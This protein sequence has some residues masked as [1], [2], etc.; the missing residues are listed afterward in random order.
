MKRQALSRYQRDPEGRLLLDVAADRTEDLYNNFDRIHSVREL[1]REPFALRF[2]ID[3]APNEDQRSRIARSTK[4][5]FLYLTDVQ[6]H[7]VRQ[8]VRRSLVLLVAGVAL[9]FV[10][11][12]ANTRVGPESSVAAEVVAQGL[13]VAAWVALWEA[14]AIFLIDWL[15]HVGDISLYQRI[16]DA[17]VVFGDDGESLKLAP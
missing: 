2:T 3:R 16:A 13:T 12:W 7:K 5:F 17:P 11:V 14:I 10:S 1:G 15:P 6:R 8:L 4:N 9:L